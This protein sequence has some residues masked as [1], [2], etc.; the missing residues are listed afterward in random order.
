MSR[1]GDDPTTQSFNWGVISHHAVARAVSV[2]FAYVCTLYCRKITSNN[3]C[4]LFS[5][6][7]PI[8]KPVEAEEVRIS[9]PTYV[10]SIEIIQIDWPFVEPNL[11][12]A[13]TYVWSGRVA[14]TEI[15]HQWS[16]TGVTGSTSKALILRS[17]AIEPIFAD[18]DRTPT[19]YNTYWMCHMCPI[20]ANMEKSD[21]YRIINMLGSHGLVS[22]ATRPSDVALVIPI[23]RLS[24]AGVQTFWS[25]CS[26][27]SPYRFG[28]TIEIE[29][30]K[31]KHHG[32]KSTGTKHDALC[33]VFWAVSLSVTRPSL[34]GIHHS[35]LFRSG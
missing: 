22:M 29:W 7:Q 10:R 3:Q 30:P 31:S 23:F 14:M 28:Q 27:I 11:G 9:F 26:Q 32:N 35:F 12:W 5:L 2:Y 19:S 13:N 8:P 33:N 21:A 17:K 1:N 6:I 24:E 18:L 25:R 34:P 15:T 16:G 4:N 20:K